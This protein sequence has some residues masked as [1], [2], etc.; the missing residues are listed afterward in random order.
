MER[1]AEEPMLE[2][3]IDFREESEALFA[4]LETVSEHAWNQPTQFKGWTINDVIAHLHVGNY[5]ADLSLTDSA[6]FVTFLQSMT[7]A[8]PKRS[9]HLNFTHAWL[10]EIKD[11]A[12]L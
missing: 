2:Q 1:I 5:M 6:A 11:G 9:G 7:A 8:R 10:Q 4:L 3:A 12:L